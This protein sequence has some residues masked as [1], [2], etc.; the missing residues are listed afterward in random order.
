MKSKKRVKDTGEVFTPRFLIREM[1]DCVPDEVWFDP[2]KRWLEPSA[3]DGN[4]LVE[5]KARLLQAGHDE[6]HVLEN[7]L[8]SVELI[9]D[10][11]W[12]LQ[13]RLGYLINGQP[14]PALNPEHFALAK[15]SP[16]TQDL[17][18]K[19]PYVS[20]GCARDE[21]IHH[22]NHICWSALDKSGF[23]ATNGHEM[24]AFGRVDDVPTTLPI[25]KVRKLGPWPETDTPDIGHPYVVEKMLGQM[26]QLS[27]STPAK[28][29]PKHEHINKVDW[30]WINFDK[31]PDQSRD[32]AQI[33]AIKVDGVYVGVG[34]SGNMKD[35]IPNGYAWKIRTGLP[36]GSTVIK[37]LFDLACANGN[38]LKFEAEFLEQCNWDE[39]RERESYWIEKFRSEGQPILNATKPAK[40]K[41]PKEPKPKPKPQGEGRG[42]WAV[43][44]KHYGTG[45]KI[46][47][48]FDGKTW[49]ADHDA[50][51][52]DINV[53]LKTKGKRDLFE[54]PRPFSSSS[55]LRGG[56]K[57]WRI[58]EE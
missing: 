22:R 39:R 38:Y 29:E 9:D 28:R 10:N 14:N 45:K 13:H 37:Q 31:I 57:L 32:K 5:V 30:S 8:F 15:I 18:H 44:P 26:S 7:M 19:N 17:N 49:E 55:G 20:V 54:D 35:R 53:S 41:L 36:D 47:S 58:Y 46:T 12:V 4:F 51:V 34:E 24:M 50:L 16:L 23:L 27:H 6:V 56:D 40:P 3:G 1:L 52:D 48:F 25:K 33:Y 43:H 42:G 11:H 21:I 2:N